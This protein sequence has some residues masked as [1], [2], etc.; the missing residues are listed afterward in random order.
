MPKRENHDPRGVDAIDDAIGGVQDLS[1]GRKP[2]LL[3]DSALLPELREIS[4]T[5]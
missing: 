1:I 4:H 5:L 3:H 2:D